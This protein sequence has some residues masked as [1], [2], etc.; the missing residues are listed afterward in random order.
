MNARC[1]EPMPDIGDVVAVRRAWAPE[2]SGFGPWHPYVLTYHLPILGPTALLAWQFLASWTAEQQEL[3][4]SVPD[5]AAMLGVMPG[6]ARKT[7]YRIASHG[8]ASWVDGVFVVRPCLQ[9]LNPR[10]RERI[11]FRL[12]S[13]LDQHDAIAGVKGQS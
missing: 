12:P 5:L 3:D 1:R 6:V 8:A 13:V 9:L 11:R 2:G 7:L 10:Q 4:V